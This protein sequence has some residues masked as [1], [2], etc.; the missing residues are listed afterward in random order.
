MNRCVLG[1]FFLLLLPVLFTSC[2]KEEDEAI[3]SR[4]HLLNPWQSEG[5]S[6]YIHGSA[7][8]SN[9]KSWQKHLLT[10]EAACGWHVY[11]FTGTSI[12]SFRF[13]KGTSWTICYGPKGTTCSNTTNFN[14]DM[15]LTNNRDIWIADNGSGIPSI[16]TYQPV[17]AGCEGG[18]EI[19]KPEAGNAIF[20]FPQERSYAYGIRPT[21]ATWTDVQSLYTIWKENFL[22]RQGDLVRVKFDDP[23]YTVSEGIGYGML[24]SVFMDNAENNTRADFD[25]LW[26]YYQ[27]HSN[28]GSGLMDWKIAGFTNSVESGAASDADLDVA[29]ALMMAYRQW[30]DVSYWNAALNLIQAIETYEIDENMYLKPGDLWNEAKNPSYFSFTAFEL[31]A[32]AVPLNAQKWNTIKDKHYSLILNGRNASTGLIANW[33]DTDGNPVDPGNG[34]GPTYDDFGFDAIRVPWRAAWAY[35]WFGHTQA[36]NIA[37]KLAQ[38][39]ESATQGDPSAIRNWYSLNGTTS[40]TYT[41]GPAYTGAFATACMANADSQSYLNLLWAQLKAQTG[42]DNTTYYHSSLQVLY[43]LLLSGNMPNL[44]AITP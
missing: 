34:Y 28:L 26:T 39:S 21:F 42:G 11:E 40:Q 38:W 8:I 36:Q 9:G 35:V 14:V 22:E 31:F 15:Q 33:T 1:I 32:Q 6:P 10:Q 24:I 19:Q 37:S 13:L 41:A 44:Y 29:V 3:T 17:I 16:T 27:A 20:A 25:G 18:N 4:I 2:A 23:D 5:A 30:N 43:A 7:I 12:A